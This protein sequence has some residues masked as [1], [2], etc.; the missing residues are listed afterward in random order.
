MDKKTIEQNIVTKKTDE[1]Y[2][3]EVFNNGKLAWTDTFKTE[4]ELNWFIRN[5][6]Y[7]K[8][9]GS[10]YL[11]HDEARIM[12]ENNEYA[13]DVF[14]RNP[15]GYR[16]TSIYH[17]DVLPEYNKHGFDVEFVNK[18]DFLNAKNVPT[19]DEAFQVLKDVEDGKI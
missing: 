18:D 5:C 11:S 7:G 6:N 17:F 13:V 14:Y 19:I 2:Y 10:V 12:L 8:E 9:L 4:E 3:V 15:L 16:F 1:G